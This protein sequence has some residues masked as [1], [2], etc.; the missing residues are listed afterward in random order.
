MI[1]RNRAPTHPGE[2]LLHEFLAPKD[3]SQVALSGKLGIPIQRINTLINGKR[4]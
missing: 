4:G 1:P 2:T 3:L